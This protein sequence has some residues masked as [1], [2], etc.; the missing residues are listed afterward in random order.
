VIGDFAVLNPDSAEVFVN[1]AADNACSAEEVV[2]C[3]RPVANGIDLQMVRLT[4][5]SVS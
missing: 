3:E 1:E 5:A 2:C 4:C